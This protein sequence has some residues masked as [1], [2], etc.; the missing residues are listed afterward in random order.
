M[1][2][3]VIY[4]AI[5]VA[6]LLGSMGVSAARG[7][8][9]APVYASFEGRTVDLSKGW[10]GAE[11]C[12]E[13]DGLLTC[14]GSEAEMDLAHPELVVSSPVGQARD[15][16]APMAACSSSLR[17]YD[18]SNYASPMIALTTRQTVHNLSR[19]GFDKKTSSYRVG[20][21]SARL[22][23]AANLGGSRYPGPTSA[24]SSSGTMQAGWNNTISSAFLD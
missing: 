2:R 21:C 18:G 7:I 4:S 15:E 5:V 12:V 23:N 10:A 17:L 1:L 6:G 14:Y 19:Y 20:A 24:N 8:E 13:T 11:A 16:V 22:H 3:F 9:T